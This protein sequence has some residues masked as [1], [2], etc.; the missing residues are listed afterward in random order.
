MNFRA[1]AGAGTGARAGAAILTSWSR[2]WAKMERLNKTADDGIVKYLLK[3]II[4]LRSRGAGAEKAKI[5]SASDT[6]K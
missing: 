4:W 1:T 6:P 2:S 5:G 3:N